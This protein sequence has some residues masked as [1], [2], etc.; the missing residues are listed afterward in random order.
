M[1]SRGPSTGRARTVRILCVNTEQH[2]LT[3]IPAGRAGVLHVMHRQ[4]LLMLHLLRSSVRSSVYMLRL[5]WRHHV[6]LLYRTHRAAHPANI[7]NLLLKTSSLIFDA[8]D[9]LCRSKVVVESC[10]IKICIHWIIFLIQ[11]QKIIFFKSIVGKLTD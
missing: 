1:P 11:N 9:T 7:F 8:F 3:G 4:Y 10:I 5:V 6:C 2:R